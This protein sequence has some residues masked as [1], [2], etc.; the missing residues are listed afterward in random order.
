MPSVSTASGSVMIERSCPAVRDRLLN[1]AL[2]LFAEKGYEATSVR[3]IALAAEV[4]KPTLYYYFKNKEGLYLETVEHLCRIIENAVMLSSV[5]DGTVREKIKSFSLNILNMAIS[6]K[7][8]S[9]LLFEYSKDTIFIIHNRIATSIKSIIN[10]IITDGIKSSNLT[11]N[12]DDDFTSTL[13]AHLIFS[14]YE[15]LFLK[16]TIDRDKIEKMLDRIIDQ[17]FI[18]CCCEHKTNRVHYSN[19]N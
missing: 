16:R 8:S 9:T 6:Y 13:M 2:Q 1:V 7:D 19:M 11:L 3:K 17:M 4:T 10:E 12:R 18:E 15:H 5:S 14:Y